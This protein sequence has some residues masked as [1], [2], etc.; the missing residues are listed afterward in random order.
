M[1]DGAAPS[2]PSFLLLMDS[3]NRDQPGRDHPNPDEAIM[4]IFKWAMSWAYP[5]L[6][7]R[8]WFWLRQAGHLIVGA[9][10]AGFGWLLIWGSYPRV[11]VQISLSVCFGFM[12]IVKEINE[13]DVTQ[14][15]FK[16]AVDVISN[17]LGFGLAM[18]L[19]GVWRS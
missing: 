18:F 9:S 6:G 8:G 13:D 16:T 3:L 15:R 19:P 17:L 4:D 10:V 7:E 11:V 14:S 5:I 12:L 2:L 1:L